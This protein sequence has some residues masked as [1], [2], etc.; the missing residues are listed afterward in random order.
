MK[1]VKKFIFMPHRGQIIII[2]TEIWFKESQVITVFECKSFSLR[3]QM[4][5]YYKFYAYRVQ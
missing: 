5:C 2:I 3:S 1:S 4:K